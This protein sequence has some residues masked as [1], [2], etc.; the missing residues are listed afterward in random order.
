MRAITQIVCYDGLTA[1][2]P[3][4]A[5]TRTSFGRVCDVSRASQNG[6][7]RPGKPNHPASREQVGP[8]ERQFP[9]SAHV[10]SGQNSSYGA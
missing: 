1:I 8:L 7:K 3:A 10:S 2:V 4:R 6:P 5:I 9:T